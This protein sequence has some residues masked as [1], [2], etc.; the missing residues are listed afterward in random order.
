M[1]RRRKTVRIV[2]IARR[3]KTDGIILK[4]PVI[5]R[6]N[7]FRRLRQRIFFRGDFCVFRVNSVSE[8]GNGQNKRNNKNE[9]YYYRSQK[10]RFREAFFR[11]HIFPLSR[12]YPLYPARA[13]DCRTPVSP[14]SATE[15]RA[16]HVYI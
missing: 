6:G 12:N 14:P 16:P 10:H 9:R 1:R 15:A 5:V 13:F 4:M 8:Y 3:K 7:R 2:E 11:S